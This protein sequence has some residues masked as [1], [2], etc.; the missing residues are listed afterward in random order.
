ML[1]ASKRAEVRRTYRQWRAA[2]DLTQ[3]N[4]AVLAGIARERYWKIENGYEQPTA[5][6]Q[7]AIARAFGLPLE[8]LQKQLA[9]FRE[10]AA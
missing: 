5:D 7:V 4:T 9:A 8:V 1:A 3:M 6:E 10:Q 2:A